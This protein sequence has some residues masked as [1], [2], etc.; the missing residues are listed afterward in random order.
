MKETVSFQLT[1]KDTGADLSTIYVISADLVVAQLLMERFPKMRRAV[2]REAERL[3][4][5]GRVRDLEDLLGLPRNDAAVFVTGWHWPRGDGEEGEI[6]FSR[7]RARVMFAR[8]P[9]LN[10]RVVTI[11]HDRELFFQ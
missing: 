6:P 10:E 1:D 5:K 2:R 4:N 9:G 8:I 11:A 3:A 7:D